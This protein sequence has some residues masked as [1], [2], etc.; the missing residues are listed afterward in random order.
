M[1]KIRLTGIG[2][3]EKEY[4]N[5]YS[6]IKL[7]NN[8]EYRKQSDNAYKKYNFEKYLVNENNEKFE[9]SVGARENG[10]SSISEDGTMHFKGM[11]DLTKYDAT[12][13]VTLYINYDDKKIEV[14]LMK[15]G[16]E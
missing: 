15:V 16:E 6:T 14:E 4:W 1:L 13:I 10:G 5:Y 7:E 9:L 2:I 8:E 12:D 3:I 11:F